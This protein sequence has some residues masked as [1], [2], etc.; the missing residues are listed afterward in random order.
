MVK[1]CSL[2]VSQPD[3][4]C[5]W[6]FDETLG[7]C[8]LEVYPYYS[9]LSFTLYLDAPELSDCEA[10]ELLD[11]GVR[12]MALIEGAWTPIRFYSRT[13]NSTA[14]D[15]IPLAILTEDSHVLVRDIP[16][17]GGNR[18]YPLRLIRSSEPVHITEYLCGDFAQPNTD[19]IWIQYMTGEVNKD[20][21]VWYLDDITLRYWDGYCLRVI[22]QQDFSNSTLR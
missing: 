1:P 11:R 5:D 18:T 15:G 3:S 8:Y 17:L 10:P 14:I 21:N 19:F 6:P 7:G 16:R 4:V 22:V 20:E 13:T 9:E 2:H 12:L